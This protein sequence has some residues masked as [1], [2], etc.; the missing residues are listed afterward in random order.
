MIAAEQ[1]KILKREI[2][3]IR[4]IMGMSTRQFGE[5]MGGLERCQ[6]VRLESESPRKSTVWTLEKVA[7]VLSGLHRIER[8]IASSRRIIVQSLNERGQ[9]SRLA[10]KLGISRQLLHAFAQTNGRLLQKQLRRNRK[11]ARKKK[12]G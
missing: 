5:L 8:G 7:A 1:Q 2:R 10:A 6:I 11:A 9:K 4:R 12:R 3:R